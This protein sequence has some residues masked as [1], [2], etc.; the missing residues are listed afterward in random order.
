MLSERE[1][2]LEFE[3]TMTLK[4]GAIALPELETSTGV[5]DLVLV[6]HRS[7]SCESVV[8][9]RCAALTNG[10]AAVA[11]R[12]Q[13]LRAHRADYL[14]RVT[15]LSMPDTLRYL[16]QLASVG[17]ALESRP[18]AWTLSDGVFV[19]QL[20]LSVLEFKLTDWRGALAQ[21]CRYRAMADSVTV[22][23]P[24]AMS[25]LDEEARATFARYGI[26]LV[27]FESSTGRKRV[28]VRARS[29]GPLSLSA[30]LD[31]IG[32]AAGRSCRHG[33]SPGTPCN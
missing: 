26:G 19:H 2:A 24:A 4:P 21:A 5:P 20:R 22:V 25:R 7:G 23:M 18:G 1:F 15:G 3:R 30:K 16:R 11:A 6:E 10:R 32:R 33:E 14:S 28:L 12:L 27:A 31:A 9:A 13:R 29:L 17:I 8:D